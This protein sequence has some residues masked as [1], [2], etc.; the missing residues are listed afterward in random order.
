MTM[1]NSTG[2]QAWVTGGKWGPFEGRMLSTSY[3]K[4]A[5]LAVLDEKVGGVAQGGA[6]TLPVRFA[7]GIMRALSPQKTP[8]LPVPRGL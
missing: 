1:I 3:G 8:L 5:L 6:F 2:G 7:S 4:S